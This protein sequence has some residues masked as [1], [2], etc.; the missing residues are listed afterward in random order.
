MNTDKYSDMGAAVRGHYRCPME[1][2]E[3]WHVNSVTMNLKARGV[4]V[5]LSYPPGTTV[6]CPAQGRECSVYDH[7]KHRW[8]HLA[9]MPYRAIVD[10]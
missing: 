8:R 6:A 7:R 4:A 5:A 1:L 3:P 2:P 9:Q 10:R